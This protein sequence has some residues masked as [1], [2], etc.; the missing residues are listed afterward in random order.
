MELEPL[1]SYELCSVPSSLIDEHSC[2]CKGNKSGLIKHLSVLEILPSAPDIVIVDVSQ[3]FYCIV[4]PHH[5]SV[6]DLMSSIQG[7]LVRY[8]DGAEKIIVFDK[9]QDISAKDHERVRRAGEVVN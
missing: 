8:T 5:G 6:S 4:W 3:L 7:C 9:Y 1:F 2:L